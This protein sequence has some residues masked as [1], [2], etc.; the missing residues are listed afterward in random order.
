MRRRPRPSAAPVSP[1]AET[2]A[3]LDG[4][5]SRASRRERFT[6]DEALELL[7]SVL[8]TVDDPLLQDAL[9]STVPTRDPSAGDAL[10]VD[11]AQ[12]LDVLLDMRLVLAG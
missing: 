6:P 7:R 12:V 10:V 2:L 3:L 11:R 8:A 9:A 4:A 5:L 1:Q